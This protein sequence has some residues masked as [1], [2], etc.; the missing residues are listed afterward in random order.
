M[1]QKLKILI[2][3][4]HPKTTHDNLS[5]KDKSFLS[6]I[7]VN[8]NSWTTMWLFAFGSTWSLFFP[9]TL[10]WFDQTLCLP[11][12]NPSVCSV[13]FSRS[14]V[15]DSLWPRESQHAR[16]PCPSPIPRVHSD[17]YPSSQWR[18]PAISPSVVPFSSCPQSLPASESFPM[19]QLFAWG[20]Q[21]IG[22]L[23]LATFLP[24]KSQL[25]SFR[26]D[27]LDLFAVQ[28]TLKSLLQ[29]HS[30]KASILRRSAFFTV[31]LSHPFMQPLTTQIKLFVLC[32]FDTDYSSAHLAIPGSARGKEPTCLCRG[33]KWHMFD[34]WVGKISWRRPWQPIPVFLSGKF[35]GQKS[36]VG[37]SPWGHKGWD[38]TEVT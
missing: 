36:L 30:S 12:C 4:F 21:S 3:P 10:V 6:C 23:A 13:Q 14:V 24:K 20:G 15:S 32:S 25:I 16:P 2:G 38:T 17:S 22:V 11:N 31:Q 18:H 9:R 19:S 29:H 34:P 26:M 27:W 28:G 35:H 5:L 8:Q 1:F 37:C 7:W 33:H